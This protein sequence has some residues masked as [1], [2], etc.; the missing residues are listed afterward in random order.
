VTIKCRHDNFADVIAD[1]FSKIS[2]I[3]SLIRDF[4]ADVY[5]EDK[6]YMK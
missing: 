6:N 2:V 1:I 5:D 4:C 3:Y